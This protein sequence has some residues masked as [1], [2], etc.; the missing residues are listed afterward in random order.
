M[1]VLNGASL[2]LLKALT[3]LPAVGAGLLL[4]FWR[5]RRLHLSALGSVTVFAAASAG[6]GIYVLNHVGDPRW[7]SK[8]EDRLGAPALT[9]TPAVGRFMGPLEDLIRSVAD[10][11]NQ[12]MDFQAALPVALEFFAAAGWA[13]A[14]SAP[15]ALAALVVG[16]VEAKRRKAEFLEYKSQ[17]EKLRLELEVIKRHL[18]YPARR[19]SPDAS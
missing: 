2:D 17:V 7:S 10:S 13:L 9:E 4:G 15:L 12:F 18:G 5:P 3:W 1:D 11:V 14:A 19:E 16:Y 6:A 8:A